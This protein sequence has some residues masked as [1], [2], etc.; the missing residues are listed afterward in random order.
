MS[1]PSR[2]AEFCHRL[3]KDG[4]LAPEDF[5]GGIRT[6]VRDACRLA[7]H[8]P[9]DVDLVFNITPMSP[10]YDRGKAKRY[11]FQAK[12]DGKNFVFVILCN[13]AEWKTARYEKL[14]QAA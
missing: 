6:L 2:V 11:P 4:V 14:R 5:T 8:A 7:K 9:N 10:D 12:V 13:E 1:R 3:I